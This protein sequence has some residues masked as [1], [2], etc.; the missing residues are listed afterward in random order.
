MIRQTRRAAPRLECVPLA[1]MKGGSIDPPD[2]HGVLGGRVDVG[3]SMKG[4]SIDP[5]DLDQSAGNGITK[6]LQ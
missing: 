2:D 1:S 6:V 4:G 5:P 3:A